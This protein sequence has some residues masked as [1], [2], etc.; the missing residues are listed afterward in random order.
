MD[1]ASTIAYQAPD[2]SWHDRPTAG[3]LDGWTAVAVPDDVW[4][5][6]QTA[7][8]EAHYARQTLDRAERE[9]EDAERELSRRL[10]PPDDGVRRVD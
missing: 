4:R 5:S 1:D 8:Q 3:P 9:Q 6:R 7:W 2:G 10:T